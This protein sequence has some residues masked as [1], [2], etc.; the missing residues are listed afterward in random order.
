MGGKLS[1]QFN[2]VPMT[3][4]PPAEAN[5]PYRSDTAAAP[6]PESTGEVPASPPSLYFDME[7]EKENKHTSF[8][9]LRK[10]HRERWT[11]PSMSSSGTSR[12]DQVRMCF[13]T[14]L[15]DIIR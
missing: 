11:P 5:I 4:R 14:W 6:V 9:E 13:G 3:Q 15:T 1:N 7:K 2:S 8:S 10:K 12:S